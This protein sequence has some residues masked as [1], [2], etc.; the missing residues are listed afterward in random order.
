[1]EADIRLTYKSSFGDYGCAVTF[2]DDW[3]EKCAFRNKLGKYEDNYEWHSIAKEGFPKEDGEFIV[4]FATECE[5][6]PLRYVVPH[7]Y[8]NKKQFP[9]VFAPRAEFLFEN[10]V[11]VAWMPHVGI[12]PYKGD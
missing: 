5:G 12:E 10:S 8:Y 7:C 9:D 6:E 11:P 3:Q 4:T 2:E 1:M